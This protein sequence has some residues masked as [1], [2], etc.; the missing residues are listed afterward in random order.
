MRVIPRDL[1]LLCVSFHFDI[2][3]IRRFCRSGENL[4]V[5]VWYTLWMQ[6]IADISFTIPTVTHRSERAFLLHEL[7]NLYTISTNKDENRKRYYAYLR[8]HHPNIL[9]KTTF[10]KEWWDTYKQEFRDSKL[11][12]EQKYLDAIKENDF[13]WWGRF[14]H[15]KGDEGNSALRYM[16][17]VARDKVNRDGGASAY[18]MGSCLSTEST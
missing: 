6:S 11:P 8:L 9:K 18:I 13:R 17:S 16:I 7:Y 5:V 10:N 2:T 3:S 15:L 1:L 12:K 14:S 4:L